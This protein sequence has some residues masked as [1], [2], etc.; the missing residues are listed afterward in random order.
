MVRAPTPEDVLPVGDAG[1]TVEN[2]IQACREKD[3]E[4]LRSLVAAPVRDD[5]IQ[6]LFDRGSDVRLARR[7]PAD[8][9]D[10]RATVTVRLDIRRDGETERVER[11]WELEQ[12]A[13]GVWRF[14]ALPD[15]F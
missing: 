1:V 10:G 8:T 6:A 13:D 5:E 12:G 2:A 14:T 15:C 4:L 11:T 7:T 3:G 9:E